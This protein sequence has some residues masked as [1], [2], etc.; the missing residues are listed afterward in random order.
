MA[1]LQSALRRA[2]Q[3]SGLKQGELAAR[4]GISRQ[5][6]SV[7]E[8]GRAEPTTLV[9]L[10]LSRA[11]GCR[12]EELFW[13]SED[14]GELVAEVSD[15]AARTI[16]RSSRA[17]VGSVMGRWVAHP[18]RQRDPLGLTT[19]ADALVL[20]RMAQ[21]D[22][23]RLHALRPIEA[24]Q[25]NV[26]LIGCDPGL[27]VLAGR[28]EDRWPGQRL[29]W[30]AASSDASLKTLARGQVHVAGAHLFDEEAGEYNV[31]FVRRAFGGK[32]MVVITFAHLEEGFAVARGNP[33]RIR[34]P[35]H[36]ARRGVRFVNREP[37]AGARR[38][39]DR[40]LR[41]ARVPASSVR[42]YDRL[43]D[44]HL[45]VAQAVAMG[46]ADVGVVARSAAL[47][48]GLDFVPLSE[49]RFDLVF[50]KEWS[51]DARA[52]RIIETLESRA[53]RRELAS[54]GGYDTRRSGQLVTELRP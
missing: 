21:R 26:L 16:S 11:L 10:R 38:L 17:L 6:L 20:A 36:I 7:L 8:S 14:G 51:S 42:G 44:G 47:A 22:R 54:L 2:R 30:I 5:T 46:A 15:G 23:V 29:C 9:A 31:P 32:S 35:E 50:A 13:L 27:A 41:K 28:F 3:K 45:Q 33:L 43:L 37:G 4:A 48:H 49:E 53:F 40:L 34:K 39:L 25:A 18:L 12:V 52:G 1:R 24:L 19:P